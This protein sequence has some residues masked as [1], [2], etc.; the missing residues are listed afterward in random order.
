MA[1]TPDQIRSLLQ[2]ISDNLV[3][4]VREREHSPAIDPAIPP[5]IVQVEQL[6]IAVSQVLELVAPRG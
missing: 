4:I 6:K 5:L 2:E 3:G 1:A